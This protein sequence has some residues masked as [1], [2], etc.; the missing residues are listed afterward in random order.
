MIEHVVISD[1]NGIRADKIVMNVFGQVSYAF[2]QKIFRMKKVKVNGKVVHASDRLCKGDIL[3]IF[4]SKDAPKQ[5]SEA[6]NSDNPKI[7]NENARYAERFRKMIIFENNDFLAINKPAG[8]AV[9]KGSGINFCIETLMTAFARYHGGELRLVHR[10]DR[11]TSGILLIAKKRL[12]AQ[13][14]TTLFRENKIHKTYIAV[15]DGK[16]KKNGVIRNYLKKAIIGNEE[17]MIVTEEKDGQRAVTKYFSKEINS[18]DFKYYT[19]LELRPETGRKHQLRVHC[20]DVLHA[21]ILGDR[22]YNKNSCYN[23][24]FLH[25]Y[26]VAIEDYYCFES[27]KSQKIEIIAEIP[28]YFPEN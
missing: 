5:N 17:K 25:A 16:I 11:D 12:A 7:D 26:K 22:K 4:A 20:A 8:I 9:Q 18:P 23:H 19:L 14:L 1:E 21:P 6:K 13:K 15:V 24:M 28:S 10:L 3:K 27:K 2:L